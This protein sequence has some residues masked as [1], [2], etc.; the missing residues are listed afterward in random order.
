M[1]S[2]ENNKSEF[3]NKYF[4][5]QGRNNNQKYVSENKLKNICKISKNPK[6]GYRLGQ[7]GTNNNFPRKN[8]QGEL[9]RPYEQASINIIAINK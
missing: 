8:F 7:Y 5:Y 2:D 3:M 4:N 1:R 9:Q 6:I